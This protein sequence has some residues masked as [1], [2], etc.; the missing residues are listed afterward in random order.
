MRGNHHEQ[1]VLFHSAL[2][3]AVASNS[4]L[5]RQRSSVETDGTESQRPS[6][7]PSRP[8]SWPPRVAEVE[9]RTLSERVLGRLEDRIA[10][11]HALSPAAGG[12]MA[13]AHP[14]FLEDDDHVSGLA[15]QGL[16][17]GGSLPSTASPAHQQHTTVLLQGFPEYYNRHNLVDVLDGEGFL[18][19]YDFVYMPR[20][21]RAGTNFG[22]AFVNL[23][24]HEIASDFM[25]HFTSFTKWVT[26][27]DASFQVELSWSMSM[28]GYTSHV[29]RFRNSPVM[30]PSVPDE[31]KPAVYLD[32]VRQ[33]FPAPTVAIRPPR[34]RRGVRSRRERPVGND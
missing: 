19:K 15:A 3:G 27:G 34:L 10:S 20:D 31:C 17:V 33:E 14:S 32:G 30:H 6:Q 28:Q 9:P 22:Y 18:A 12:T 29:D 4:P 13:T 1:S 5:S 8:R 11:C 25:E 26:E 7:H 24:S 23:I 21:F 16:Q 2:E